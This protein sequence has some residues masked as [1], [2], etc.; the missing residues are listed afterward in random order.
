MDL[1]IEPISSPLSSQFIPHSNRS[2]KFVA[3]C[4]KLS[5]F[6]PTFTLLTRSSKQV[7]EEDFREKFAKATP[8]G[9]AYAPA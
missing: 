4:K 6:N 1:D 8:A 7:S 5:F 3:M 9:A 2:K